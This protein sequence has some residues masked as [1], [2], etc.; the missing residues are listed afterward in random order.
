MAPV[1][2]NQPCSFGP[3]SVGIPEGAVAANERRQ[4][5][6][7]F[8]ALLLGD[9]L[10]NLRGS[11]GGSWLGED[12]GAGEDAILEMAEQQMVRVLASQDILGIVRSLEAKL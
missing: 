6:E 9:V 4:A 11:L 10:K 1:T 2:L 3:F 5:Y 12:A 8:E 7:D